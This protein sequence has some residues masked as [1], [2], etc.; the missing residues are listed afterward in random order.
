MS[1]SFDF[2]FW[3][4]VLYWISVPQSWFTFSLVCKVFA[5]WCKEESS[6]RKMQ[7]LIS[8]GDWYRRYPKPPLDHPRI[9]CEMGGILPNGALHG[10]FYNA[11][12]LKHPVFETGW[13]KVG[14]FYMVLVRNSL[15]WCWP[16]SV[17]IRRL[18]DRWVIRAMLCEVCGKYHWFYAGSFA[19]VRSCLEKRY[20]V[21]V[22]K[23][24]NGDDFMPKDRIAISVIK[25]AQSIK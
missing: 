14:T 21:L 12:T 11:L 18:R 19:Y 20:Y 13:T 16:D 17:F 8:L 23:N 7:F 15:I 25:Y 4:R 5:G 24:N 10:K 3:R 22:L 9:T 2:W 1:G 6:Q